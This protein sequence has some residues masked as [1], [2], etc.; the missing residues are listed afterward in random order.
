MQDSL[1]GKQVLLVAPQFF[2]YEKEIHAE[3]E[4]RGAQVDFIMDRPFQSAFLKAVTKVRPELVIQ[5]ADRF[6]ASELQRLGNK[7]YDLVFVI[8]GQ[9][10]STKTL[11]RWRQS[12]PTACFILYMWDSFANRPRARDN[13][14]HFDHAYTF[15]RQD[16]AQYGIGFRPLF[17][18]PGFE[19]PS[20]SDS[21]YDISF[22]G[23]AHTDRYAVA[24]AVRQALPASTRVFFYLYLQAKWV[25]WVYK[26]INPAFAK[27]Q[28]SDF[29]FDPLM[30]AQV[31]EIF[32]DSR[33]ILDIE[34]PEQTG[35]TMRT[36]ETLGA[37]KKLITTN[38]SIRDYDFYSAAN[39]CII[40]RKQ[41]VIA[42]DFL[43][44]DYQPVNA[45]IYQKYRIKGWLDELVSQ[46]NRT[47]A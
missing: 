23:T 7:A 3:L 46:M 21:R 26:L 28:F 33:I 18:S 9:T 42:A 14:I 43:T 31:Q 11:Q 15:D 24:S 30:K 36:L 12:L 27:A 8:S 34:H 29:R 35:L 5:I 40:D 1:A 6:Y 25:Y 16:A 4:R 13:L 37:Q 32:R 10:L 20:T 45:I 44:S 39:I 22:V 2:G 41:P 38:T 17:F 47:K 19:A